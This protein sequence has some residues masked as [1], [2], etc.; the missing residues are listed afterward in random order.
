MLF[1]L[2]SRSSPVISDVTV[3]PSLSFP[4]QPNFLIGKLFSAENQ[5]SFSGEFLLP[6]WCPLFL[7]H[8]PAILGWLLVCKRAPIIQQPLLIVYRYLRIPPLGQGMLSL[9]DSVRA[10]PGRLLRDVNSAWWGLEQRLP[11][12]RGGSVMS[13]VSAASLCNPC[14]ALHHLSGDLVWNHD[15]QPLVLWTAMSTS[16]QSLLVM[17]HAQVPPG[18]MDQ[19][20]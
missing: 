15:I 3:L 18:L 4:Y 14:H 19:K 5:L 2:K 16:L 11:V 17:Q 20:L 9:P 12:T 8:R 6:M 10:G 1:L 13:G 7:L